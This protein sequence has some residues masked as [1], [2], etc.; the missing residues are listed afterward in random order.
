[1]RNPFSLV[2]EPF[3]I[4][5]LIE[6]SFRR[7][8]SRP[9]SIGKRRSL[10]SEIKAREISR[11][12][13]ISD[14]IS[15]KLDSIVKNFPN[16]EEL[17]PLYR[18]LLEVMGG[19]DNVK[20][21][22]GAIFWASRMIKRLL[23]YYS[24]R[25]RREDDPERM[26]ELR[27]EFLGRAASILRRVRREIDFLREL[28]PRLKELPD[29]DTS[30]PTVIIAGM[31]NTGKSTLLSK[32]TSKEPEIAPYPFTTKGLIIGHREVP[33]LGTVQFVDTPGLLDR[34]LA[35]RNE[36]ELQAIAA[37]RHFRGPV[38][39]LI[40]PTET[41]GYNLTQQLSLLRELIETLEKR[42]LA[43]LNKL[44]LF[45]DFREN[46]MRVEDELGRIGVRSLRIS[47][48]KG[49]GL[50]ELLENLEGLLKGNRGE[51]SIPLIR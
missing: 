14:T 1:M 39:Y 12:Q 2:P 11:M 4:E 24:S 30:S 9:K 21:S 22:L 44:D 10:L 50:D 37:L 8:F 40:D 31:P 35:E 6:I 45:D 29:L 33:S 25:I 47:A 26:A 38:L 23:R 20:H 49:E 3:E 28:I 41:C 15:S 5:E 13:S 16:V 34:P 18:E 46:F 32:M 48:E 36:M 27:S 7:A 42:Y 43:V 17:D 51:G 19:I